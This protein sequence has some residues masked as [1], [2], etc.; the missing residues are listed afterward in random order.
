MSIVAL[1]FL[2]GLSVLA[3][4]DTAYTLLAE[5]SSTAANNAAKPGKDR[6]PAE[7]SAKSKP[8]SSADK[9][10][11]SEAKSSAPPLASV[12][13]P[14]TKETKDDR[15]PFKL[16][17]HAQ[18]AAEAPSASGMLLR[19]FGALLFIVGLIAAAGWALRYFGIINF[20]KQQ[21]EAAGLKVLDTVPLGE[22]RTLT[23]VKF[24][25]RTLLIGSTPQ[26]LSLLA[27]QADEP[28]PQANAMPPVRTVTD[29]LDSNSAPQFEQELA[30]VS[31][32]N[33]TWSEWRM[34]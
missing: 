10:T 15:L 5:T 22:R 3:Q 28:E 17:D 9:E 34:Q 6:P 1:T 29:L 8:A 14:P 25:E 32:I 20:G 16:N 24:G 4:S 13:E 23:L 12:P 26:G 31:L 30:R 19:T 21:S 18:L 11:K 7:A 2:I 33:T 27:E